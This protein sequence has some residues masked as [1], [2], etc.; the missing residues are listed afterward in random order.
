MGRRRPGAEV[1]DLSGLTVT[2]A[3]D[4]VLD[5]GLLPRRVAQGSDVPCA[6]CQDGTVVCGQRPRP[7]AR[8]AAG[9]RVC[10]W[11][12]PTGDDPPDDG[13]GGSRVPRGPRPLSP[14]G[15]KPF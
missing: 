11:C 10:F 5:A 12:A 15:S 13:R 9:N 2:A 4:A 14:T 7:H 1:P 3:E 8:M 6:R